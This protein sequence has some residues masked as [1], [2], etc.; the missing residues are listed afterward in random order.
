[1]AKAPAAKKSTG[2]V[3]KKAATPEKRTKQPALCGAF[4]RVTRAVGPVVKAATPAL[5][6]VSPILVA[7]GP[8]ALPASAAVV[9]IIFAIA[10]AGKGLEHIASRQQARANKQAANNNQPKA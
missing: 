2:T 10:A 1:M 4:K 3:T 7:A 8:E 5:K 9:G 6:K